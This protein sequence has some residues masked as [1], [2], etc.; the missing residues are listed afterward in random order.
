MGREKIHQRTF[1]LKDYFRSK[2]A[3]HSVL[4]L[5]T[6]AEDDL[7][8]AIQVVEVIGK[9]VREIKERLL[10]QFQIDC[11]PMTTFGL[12][13]LRISLAIYI[14]KADIDYLVEALVELATD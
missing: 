6:P 14:T 9:E 7:S 11:R 12:N 10:E 5:H 8:G 2:I 1:E 13:A 3:A 4:Q